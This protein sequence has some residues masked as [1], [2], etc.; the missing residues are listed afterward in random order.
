MP[1]KQADA[2]KTLVKTSVDATT[3]GQQIATE[4]ISAEQEAERKKRLEKQITDMA[5][6]R[7][8]Q[9]ANQRKITS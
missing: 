9:N 5:L 2:I 8:A 6:T 3:P 7:A 1:S 4:R